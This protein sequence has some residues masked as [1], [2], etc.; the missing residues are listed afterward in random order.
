[1]QANGQNQRKRALSWQPFL[2]G[3]LA[4]LLLTGGRI[5]RPANLGWVMVGDAG[6][7]LLGWM[8]FRDAPVLQQPFGANWRYGMKM[9]SSIVYSD[10]LPLFAFLFKPV[11]AALPEHFQYFGLWTLF[12]FLLQ[13]F[14]A[15][16][17]LERIE[18]GVGVWPKVL[19]TLFFVLAPAFLWRIHFHFSLGAHWLI[20]ASLYLYLAPRF[21]AG[22]WI[23][24]LV[25]A[26]LITPILL[27]DDHTRFCGGAGEA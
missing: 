3:G 6:M 9:S 21:R 16:K 11:S 2:I 20:L 26:T 23:L 4:F 17:L 7:N 27:A 12:C 13:A 19:G 22:L 10:S 14:F 5:A 1:M 18:D 15:W 8:F 25:F 24:L